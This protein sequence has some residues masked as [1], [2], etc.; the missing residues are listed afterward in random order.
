[1]NILYLCFADKE[2]NMKNIIALTDSLSPY[3]Y[4]DLGITLGLKLATIENIE[5]DFPMCG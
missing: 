3:K 1:M 4:C 5:A 2:M